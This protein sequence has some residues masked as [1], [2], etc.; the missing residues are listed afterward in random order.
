MKKI[1]IKPT[2]TNPDISKKEKIAIWIL[3]II[4]CL[5]MVGIIFYSLKT[6][7]LVQVSVAQITETEYKNIVVQTRKIHE[8]TRKNYIVNFEGKINNSYTL[9]P[10]L[11]TTPEW[12]PN[13]KWILTTAQSDD[14]QLSKIYIIKADGSQVINV[15]APA[16]SF[17][18]RWS[19][20]GKWISFS[21]SERSSYGIDTGVIVTNIGC[22]L[23]QETCIS[24][25]FHGATTA[26]WSPDG[27]QI[28]Y[29][30]PVGKTDNGGL[31]PPSRSHL[32]IADVKSQSLEI[33]LFPNF[34]GIM[35]QPDWSPDGNQIVAIC[36]TLDKANNN[37]NITD[38]C[39]MD[40]NGTS[41]SRIATSGYDL[42]PF[43]KVRF[44]PDGSKIAFHAPLNRSSFFCI[45]WENCFAPDA[46]FVMNSDG[47][48]LTRI[49]VSKNEFINWIAW[50]PN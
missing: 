46:I 45:E 43:S 7:N 47:S 13:G 15:T 50:Y 34:E 12:S 30:M 31:F 38:I 9:P 22:I 40:K 42:T 26:S 2:L 29:S 39:I 21:Y 24:K 32:F 37:H 49:D 3:I 8:G 20:N 23:G 14:K 33:E 27:K 10:N 35:T 6:G 36:H 18:P 4:I 11:G 41:L 19:P 16:N 1:D 48:N 25:K 5:L 44:S 17:D 28:V